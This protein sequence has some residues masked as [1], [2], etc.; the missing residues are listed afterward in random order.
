MSALIEAT[1]QE[2]H[3]DEGE[4]VAGFII[5]NAKIIARFRRTL[6]AESDRGCA[7]MA[8]S[9]LEH[10]LTERLERLC[11]SDEKVF[12][13]SVGRMSFANKIDVAYLINALS[14]EMRD[15]L[16]TL[17]MI[18]N[19]FAHSL[20]PLTFEE[21][22]IASLCKTLS[23]SSDA[24]RAKVNYRSCYIQS[25]LSIAIVFIAEARM[26]QP[27][28]ELSADQVASPQVMSETSCGI[29]V[30]A[31]EELAE[32]SLAEGNVDDARIYM[33]MSKLTAE[34]QS[35]SCQDGSFRSLN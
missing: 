14:K 28:E 25:C 34:M 4:L 13:R 23:L 7:L 2:C 9:Y 24:A 32:E 12:A 1:D 15:E 8:A 30:L 6:T 3:A 5:E 20:S 31:Y 19:R 18:R 26:D 22:G 16:V 21:E 27:L 29:M 33:T 10:L 17:R 35:R 11:V